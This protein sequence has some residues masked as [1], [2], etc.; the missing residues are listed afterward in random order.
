MLRCLVNLHGLGTK[1]NQDAEGPKS[2]APK[3]IRLKAKAIRLPRGLLCQKSSKLSPKEMWM[4]ISDE[5]IARF[6]F[7]CRP[8]K[9]TGCVNFIGNYNYK[10]LRYPP[11]KFSGIIFRAHRFSY[12]V[13]KGPLIS[14]LVIDH[15]C[16]NTF[17]V[18]PDHLRQVTQKENVRTTTSAGRTHCPQGHKHPQPPFSG[19]RKPC[20][21]CCRIRGRQ[22]YWRKKGEN[23]KSSRWD[24]SYNPFGK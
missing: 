18:N 14:G 10:P 20:A 2:L 7:R 5:H 13:F 12:L 22:A 21:E 1:I 6:L 16:R 8:D 15:I 9:K 11:F 23:G 4:I 19:R 17:C 3:E 24:R